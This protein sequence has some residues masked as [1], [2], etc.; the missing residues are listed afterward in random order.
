MS[1]DNGTRASL[2]VF[3]EATGARQGVAVG[4]DDTM[5]TEVH[6]VDREAD[7]VTAPNRAQ[8]I[9]TGELPVGRRLEVGDTV[10]VQCR[11]TAVM[12]GGDMA[13]APSTRVVS[14]HPEAVDA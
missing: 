9:H 11:V 14:L 2:V 13:G 12:G 5:V 1:R 3:D 8:V 7:G 6:E 10:L 4:S